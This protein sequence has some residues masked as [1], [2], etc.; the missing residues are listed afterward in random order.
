MLAH[1]AHPALRWPLE[2]M[3]DTDVLGWD[4]VKMDSFRFAVK[5]LAEILN[6][7][8]TKADEAASFLVHSPGVT[9]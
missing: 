3:S 7:T 6:E 1:S 2:A 4:S 8:L 9:A 5:R